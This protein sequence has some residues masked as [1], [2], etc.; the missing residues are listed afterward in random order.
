MSD[1]ISREVFAMVD[2]LVDDDHRF[3]DFLLS[4]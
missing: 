2:R 1:V 3:R 4:R